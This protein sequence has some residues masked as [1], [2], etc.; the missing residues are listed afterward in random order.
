[1][2]ENMSGNFGVGINKGIINSENLAGYMN[3]ASPKNLAEAAAEI[4]QILDQLSQTYP[5]NTMSD[6]MQLASKAITHI[7]NNPSLMQRVLSALK[8]GSIS[9]LSQALNHP[10]ASFVITALEDWQK[11]KKLDS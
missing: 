1:M 5:S 4:Q 6:R 3:I 9:A 11:T 10:S 7:E 8:A 2:S